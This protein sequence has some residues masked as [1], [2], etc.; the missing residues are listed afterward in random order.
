MICAAVWKTI[1]HRPK[2]QSTTPGPFF[3]L[4]VIFFMIFLKKRKI[5][6]AIGENM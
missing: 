6:L 1:A 2:K 3:R 5:M 4:G